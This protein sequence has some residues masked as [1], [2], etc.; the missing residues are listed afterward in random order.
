MGVLE[1]ETLSL[2]ATGVLGIGQVA[3]RQLLLKYP[4]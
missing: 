2:L 3:R 4:S 1:P